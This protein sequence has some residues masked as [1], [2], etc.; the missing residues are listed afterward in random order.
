MPS[1]N[2]A[3]TFQDRVTTLHG[4]TPGLRV[5]PSRAVAIII[6]LILVNIIV[7]IA[8]GIVFHYNTAL[9]STG[10][11]AWVLGLRHA[12]DADHIAVWL[13]LLSTKLNL[14]R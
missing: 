2:L 11:L 14:P 7:W 3:R 6:F 8:A 1:Y 9:A 4:K 10:V 13:A 5:L 12:L